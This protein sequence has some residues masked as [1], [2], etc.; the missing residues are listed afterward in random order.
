MEITSVVIFVCSVAL[1]GAIAY[2]IWGRLAASSSWT[3][4]GL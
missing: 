4:D 2:S 1:V 3:S